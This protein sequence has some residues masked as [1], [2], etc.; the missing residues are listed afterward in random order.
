MKQWK[1]WLT[2]FFWATKSLQMVIAATKLKDITPWKKSYDL[3][4]STQFICQ[5]MS[6]SLRLHE[7]QHTRS[8]CPS[9]IPGVHSN[10]YP[11]SRWCH[12]TILSSVVLFSTRPQFFPASGSFQ[13]SQLFTSGGQSIGV[14]TSTSVLPMNTQD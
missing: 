6:D 14:S 4:S 11:L 1:Q 13:M 9:P 12:P 8:S 2:L 7:L 10:P 3:P 5:V